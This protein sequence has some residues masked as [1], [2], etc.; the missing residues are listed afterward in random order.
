MC[1]TIISIILKNRCD[2]EYFKLNKCLINL[3]S[4]IFNF[5]NLKKF[6]LLGRSISRLEATCATRKKNCEEC[7]RLNFR[8]PVFS[9]SLAGSGKVG[10]FKNGRKS[11]GQFKDDL[12]CGCEFLGQ[13]WPFILAGQLV[14]LNSKLMKKRENASENS[15]LQYLVLILI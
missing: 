11:A 6:S 12:K 5:R 15:Y 9:R 14:I 4:E 2:F 7:G 1:V 3:K 13:N 10:L 8:K